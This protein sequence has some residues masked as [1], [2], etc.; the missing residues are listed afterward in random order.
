[1]PDL[2]LGPAPERNRT[3]AILISIAALAA[4]AAAIFYFSPRNASQIHV[5][6]IDLFA[7]HTETKASQGS[8]HV[9]GTPSFTED[10][11]YVVVHASIENKLGMPLF[12]DS[13]EATLTTPAGVIAATVVSPT[14]AARLEQSFPALTPLATN[15]IGSDSQIAPHAKLEGSIIL[16]FPTLKQDDWQT[17]K[18]ASLTL[19]FAHIGPQTI[20]LP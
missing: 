19:N 2:N 5:E 20:T 17:K 6:K 1:M 15:P 4:M 13:P 16:L 18:S 10:N 9:L 14:D 7:P 11:L 3:P 12:L 8:T